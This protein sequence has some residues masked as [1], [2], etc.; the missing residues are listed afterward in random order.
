MKAFLW[1]WCFLLFLLFAIALSP[2]PYWQ[3]VLNSL[4]IEHDLK[5]A[6]LD[7]RFWQGQTNIQTSNLHGDIHLQWQLASLF[8][9]IRFQ[10]HHKDFRSWGSVKPANDSVSLKLDELRINSQLAN[11]A[12]KAHGIKVAGDEVVVENFYVNWRYKEKL[13]TQTQGSGYWNG[14]EL[15]YRQG[16]HTRF[17]EFAG[18][19]FRLMTKNAEPYFVLLSKLGTKYLSARVKLNGEAEAT[20]MPALL[21]DL[22]QPWFGDEN[23][24]AFVMTEQ[25]FQ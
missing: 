5:L 3:S 16:K 15:S 2:L 8:A 24:P 10:L 21:N 23:V 19:D 12:L 14:G 18:V 13:P 1:G 25:V 22:G 4:L 9:P 11:T 6:E 7:G 17:V 20:I